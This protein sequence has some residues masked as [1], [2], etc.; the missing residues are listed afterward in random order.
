MGDLRNYNGV[1]LPGELVIAG[2]AKELGSLYH[3]EGV[4]AHGDHKKYGVLCLQSYMQ[5][6]GLCTVDG[7]IVAPR[8]LLE[9]V[10]DV[11]H[12][13]ELTLFKSIAMV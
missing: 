11:L 2:D 4:G 8:H 6:D 12:H 10:S 7:D 9:F 13:A 3:L 5:H 1:R